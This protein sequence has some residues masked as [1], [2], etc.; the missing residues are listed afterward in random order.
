MQLLSS[1]LLAGCLSKPGH[2]TGGLDG[3]A[4]D[5]GVSDS[6]L[7]DSGASDSGLSDGGVSDTGSGDTGSGDTGV[8]CVPGSSPF[9]GWDK[10]VSTS[11]GS[12]SWI[13]DADGDGWSIGEGDCD[14]GDAEVH[15]GIPEIPGDGIDQD[16]DG[17]DAGPTLRLDAPAW[18]WRGPRGGDEAGYEVAFAGDT[19]GDGQQEVLVGNR[20]NGMVYSYYG[21]FDLVTIG[22]RPRDG[23]LAHIEVLDGGS[24]DGGRALAA[25]GDLNGDGYDDLAVGFEGFDGFYTDDSPR[26]SGLVTVYLGPVSGS[27][28]EYDADYR[29][30]GDSRGD[31][32][33]YALAFVP[34]PDHRGRVSLLVSDRGNGSSYQWND[35]HGTSSADADLVFRASSGSWVGENVAGGGDID[36]DGVDDLLFGSGGTAMVYVVPGP[37]S[38]SVDP[39]T[40][41]Y[42]LAPE[43]DTN[44][45]GDALASAGDLD[46]DGYDDFLV[47]Y[48]YDDEHGDRSG[49]A[50]LVR[51]PVTASGSISDA[52][53]RFVA[54]GAGDALGTSVAGLGDVN[55]DGAQDIAIG[56]PVSNAYG[57]G[58]RPGRVYVFSMPLSGSILAADADLVIQ[59]RGI[60]DGAGTSL[61]G[62]VDV[63][64]DCLPDLLVGVADRDGPTIN[65]GEV[66]LLTGLDW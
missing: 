21:S 39:D 59:G 50:W 13:I 58:T 30:Y 52:D 62:G 36:G 43:P 19:D 27:L 65:G 45:Q 44:Q 38:A 24:V 47:A 26:D 25:R 6:G 66:D 3:G 22:A 4:G 12:G 15:P 46:G 5:G 56:A 7:S 60:G 48:G 64:Q 35:L 31:K 16:C 20:G 61:A 54:E 2:D 57:G 23:A 10:G 8:E 42:A 18:W 41:G 17:S 53:A 28:D 33:G 63:D 34:N 11:T 32:L 37:F 14:D 29:F 1:L 49:A 9:A 55:G 40:S 51:G